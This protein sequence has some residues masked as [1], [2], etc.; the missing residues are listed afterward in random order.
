M[1]GSAPARSYADDIR[2]RDDTALVQLLLAR[3]DLAR[4]VPTDLTA[5]AARA[6]SRPS[7]L[8]AL[9]SLHADT[10]HVL[11]ALLIG[12]P[13][14]LLAAD[15]SAQLE[16][17]WRQALVWRSPE[18]LRPARVI[19]EL[20]PEPA[21]LGPAASSIE[22]YRPPTDL[23]VRFETLSDAARAALERLRWG[24]AKA[25]FDGP[26][27]IGVL[28]E[29]VA[30]GFMV[31]TEESTG[32]V[33]REV[34]LWLRD[35]QLVA[36]GLTGLPA[37]DLPSDPQRAQSGAGVAIRELL[38]QLER[39]A[40]LWQ[41]D[42]PRVLRTGGL[43]ARE[44][45]V[46]AERLDQDQAF[47]AFLIELAYAAQLVASDDAD[48]PVWLP[49]TEY[50]E[51]LRRDTPARWARLAFAWRDS[52]RAAFLVGTT[53]DK[54]KINAL[55]S[56]AHW[57]MMRARRR[58]VL[59]ILAT[60]SGGYSAG[61]MDE[62][63]RWLR[64]LRLPAG[65][66][67]R[68]GELLQEAEWLGVT[69]GHA[70]TAA[71]HVLADA[72]ADEAA[73]AVALVGSLPP[74]QDL[75]LVQADHTVVAPG[76]L[77]DDLRRFA[78]LIFNVESSGG[79]TVFRMT[80]G[81]LRRGFDRGLTATDILSRLQAVSP[82][83]IPQ[84]VEYLINDAARQHGQTRVGATSS[85][86]RSDD[87]AS[88]QSMMA[89]PRTGILR[90]R[91]IAPTVLVSPVAAETV[92]DVLREQ[93]HSPVAETSDGVSIVGVRRQPR[94]DPRPLAG[95]VVVDSV[96][97]ELAEQAVARL[98]QHPDSSEGPRIAS[99]DP[100]LTLATLQDA[101]AGRMPVW[102]GYSDPTGDV[103]RALLQPEQVAGGRVV[104]AVDGQRRTIAL[105]RILGV[106]PA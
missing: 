55:G 23:S 2:S 67:T 26:A 97:A 31:R 49:T 45:K 92:L 71:G 69:A 95:P 74:P 64:P 42:P 96:T 47:T 72:A 25:R 51:W 7:A 35:G 4:P 3:P 10:L 6:G 100:A 54:G 80:S 27:A 70:L 101:A 24:P 90:L 84:P 82:A 56:E 13:E 81:S 79:A 103:H 78:D 63:L 91:Q 83:P 77:S 88:L 38:W 94:A 76:A 59:E 28:E 21:G 36:G 75:L 99:T 29:L 37:P 46:T 85:Y 57:P 66:P 34:G 22:D 106:A 53:G 19:S 40:S 5:L 60:G 68:A 20:L 93:G 30:A 11:E 39:L 89:D 86:I 105:H 41:L 16:Q 9:E 17:L 44:L 52:P 43:G 8:R 102:I 15:V 98:R 58:D 61:A 33:P 50:D 87:V 1:T 12:D 14:I 73:V 65:A 18:G 104:G 32:T 48:E 62:A